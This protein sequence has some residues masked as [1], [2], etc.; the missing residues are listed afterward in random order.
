MKNLNLSKFINGTITILIICVSLS[1]CRKLPVAAE[2]NEYRDGVPNPPNTV[3]KPILGSVTPLKGLPGTVVTLAG[4]NIDP[5]IANNTV[6]VNGI[7]ATVNNVIVTSIPNGVPKVT[8]IFTVPANATSG[9]IVLK[10]TGAELSWINDFKVIDATMSTYADLGSN[11]IEHIAFDKDGIAYGDN[12]DKVLRI[13][14]A[15]QVT[16]FAGGGTNNPFKFIWGIAVDNFNE[17]YVPDATSRVIYKITTAGI[18]KIH[19]GS[20]KE[21]FTDG[22]GDAVEFGAPRGMVMDLSGNLFITDV[23]RVRKIASNGVVTTIAGST[24]EGNV[25]GK[26]A[27]ARFGSLDGITADSAGNV[28]VSDRRYLNIRKIAKNGTVTTL[29]GSGMPGLGDGAGSTATFSDP[30]GLAV[31]EQGN[32][33]VA[34]YSAATSTSAIRVVN[35]LG[36]VSTLV[37]GAAGAGVI[38]GPAATASVSVPN[39]LVTDAAGNL[40]IVNTGA[41]IIS[42][43]VFK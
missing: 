9:K 31:D 16:T 18:P 14:P 10:T 25:D 34:D 23:H 8:V 37:K 20:G 15:G 11:Y 24:E 36:F 3:G 27:A 13:S 30:R 12:I 28:Y 21:G 4:I 41:N 38:N 26:G 33:F 19:V 22:F 17:V 32:V 5:V 1:A 7:A 40:Y 43:I 42:K 35:K 29:A 39:G 2:T 6:T